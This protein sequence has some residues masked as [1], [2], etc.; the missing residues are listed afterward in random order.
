MFGHSIVI[1]E[2]EYHTHLSVVLHLL[3]HDASNTF[4]C[5]Q[6]AH[7]VRIADT[8]CHRELLS[9]ESCIVDVEVCSARELAGLS[10]V[11]L[12]AFQYIVDDFDCHS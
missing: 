2:I 11:G 1:L 9:S 4:P 8:H 6:R 10:H 7:L 12:C 5:E 3:V